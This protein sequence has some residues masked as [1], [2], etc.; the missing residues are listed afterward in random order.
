MRIPVNHPDRI[1]RIFEEHPDGENLVFDFDTRHET[2]GA[3][4]DDSWRSFV[5]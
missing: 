1:E 2:D 4:A 3:S 5:R